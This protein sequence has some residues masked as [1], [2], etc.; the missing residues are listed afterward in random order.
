MGE[1]NSLRLLIRHRRNNRLKL[2]NESFVMLVGGLGI[3]HDDE[4]CLFCDKWAT[5]RIV[6]DDEIII[7]QTCEEH[8]PLLIQLYE[9]LELG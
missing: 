2:Q 5:K 7:L 1:E 6:D 4:S 9:S 8:Y 3:V